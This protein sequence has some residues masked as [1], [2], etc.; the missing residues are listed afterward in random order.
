VK[1]FATANITQM[2]SQHQ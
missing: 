2:S 1:A